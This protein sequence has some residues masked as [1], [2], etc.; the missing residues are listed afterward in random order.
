[1]HRRRGTQ[2]LRDV[3]NK[4]LTEEEILSTADKAFSGGWTT[5]K[6]YFMMGLPT[7][8][9]EDIEGIAALGQQVV[10]RYY[11]NPGKPKGK[12]V[13][14]TVS[15]S[16]FVPK[17]FT[18]FQWEPQDTVEEL[19]EK[20][21][22]LVASVKTKKISL[23]WHDARTSFLEGVL[24]PGR[25]PVVPGDRGGLPPGCTLDSWAEHFD[26]DKW[27]EVFRDCSLDPA[28]Y[29]NRRRSY[30]EVLPWDHLDYGVSKDF[31][32]KESLR[33]GRVWSPPTAGRAV[34][35][36]GRPAGREGSVLNEHKDFV[37]IRLV[38]SKTG[39]ARYI[40]HLD[41]NRAMI[42]AIRRGGAAHLVH[43]RLQ[44]PSL[45][46]LCRPLSLGYEG[47]RE[48]MDLRLQEPMDLEELVRRLNGAMPEGLRIL[49]AA[50]AV[51]KAGEAVL[52]RYRLSIGC[53]PEKVRALL[54]RETIPVEKRT[55]KKTMK[56][57]DLKPVVETSGAVVSEG[58]AGTAL[59]ELELPCGGDLSVNP[60]LLIDALKRETGEENLR[61][62]VRRLK[63]AAADGTPFH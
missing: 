13:T 32:K 36:A 52:A 21:R 53:D 63:V 12:G 7:E 46:H 57:V 27:M 55:K 16:C 22:R 35:A 51:M 48:T 28:F 58:E 54:E 37:T 9:S 44:P 3:I 11:A 29:A 1:M 39:R 14:V 23:N 10:N 61:Y 47:E 38:F 40:S 15:V 41:L 50:P 56:T 24:G 19:Q 8:T 60:S 20:Q 34:R 62:T 2:R 6:L 49:S 42:R 33:A 25:P 5:V 17:P 4:N 31:L 26:F 45:C 59:L 18:P 30:E 43:R